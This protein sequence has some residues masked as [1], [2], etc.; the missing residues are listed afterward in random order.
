LKERVNIKSGNSEEH[1]FEEVPMVVMYDKERK[2][3]VETRINQRTGLFHVD[4]PELAWSSFSKTLSPLPPRSACAA[5]QRRR[6][7]TPL[8][9]LKTQM[10]LIR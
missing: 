5:W 7:S 1:W 4:G 6:R 2:E 3:K 8:E 10:K 9:E